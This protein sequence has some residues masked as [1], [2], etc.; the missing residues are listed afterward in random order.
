MPKP[1]SAKESSL[2]RMRI[3]RLTLKFFL[4]LTLPL[5]LLA[6]PGNNNKSNNGGANTAR[7]P[8]STPTPPPARMTIVGER[9]FEHPRKQGEVC[10]RPPRSAQVAQTRGLNRRQIVSHRL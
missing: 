5:F 7:T 10:P 2:S 1:S 4:V 8:S 9:S 3:A 6:C